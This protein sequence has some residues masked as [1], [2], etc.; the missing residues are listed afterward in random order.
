[1]KFQNIR[2]N[3]VKFRRVIPHFNNNPI[4]PINKLFCYEHTGSVARTYNN[5]AYESVKSPAPASARPQRFERLGSRWTG[6]LRVR[7]AAAQQL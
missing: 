1:M 2:K 5:E 4:N 6:V 3:S 7:E